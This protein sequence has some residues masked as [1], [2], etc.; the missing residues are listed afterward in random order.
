MRGSRK[1]R[2]RVIFKITKTRVRYVAVT[3]R[4]LAS[5]PKTLRAYLRRAKL[6]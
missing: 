4:K 3:D 2:N 5:K 6:R 1:S